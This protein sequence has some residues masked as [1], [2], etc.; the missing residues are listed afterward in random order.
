MNTKADTS[1]SW[2]LLVPDSPIFWE[3]IP[4]YPLTGAEWMR[5]ED[6]ALL[7]SV[8]F[9]VSGISSQAQ[10][11]CFRLFRSLTWR[12]SS[13]ELWLCVPVFT[14]VC[15]SLGMREG[16]WPAQREDG[17]VQSQAE[18]RGRPEAWRMEGRCF[19]G[20]LSFS[21]RPDPLKAQHP[22][23]F[24]WVLWDPLVGMHSIILLKLIW[25]AIFDLH[26]I[27]EEDECLD[28]KALCF[29][30]FSHLYT[31]LHTRFF[32][33]HMPSVCFLNKYFL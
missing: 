1:R 16:G 7:G 30:H 31:C 29:L 22:H 6:L 12:R 26:P 5:R 15:P 4:L 25:V 17:N 19:R 9:S 13:L 2:W 23:S 24:L 3:C 18:T 21:S 11:C 14:C 10:R 27:S 32:N 20:L 8:K 33:I 28:T